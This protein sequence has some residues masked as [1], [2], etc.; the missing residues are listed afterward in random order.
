VLAEAVPEFERKLFAC[1]AE[2]GDEVILPCAYSSPS[3]VSSVAACGR[4]LEVDAD[5]VQ[6]RFEVLGDFVV[7]WLESWAEAAGCQDLV[8][9]FESF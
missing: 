3:G 7:E 9:L 4:E 2:H 6:E 5:G 1:A 8:D